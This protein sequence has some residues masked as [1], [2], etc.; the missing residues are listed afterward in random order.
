MTSVNATQSGARSQDRSVATFGPKNTLTEVKNAR[1]TRVE[2]SHTSQRRE[3]D[4][5]PSEPFCERSKL[6]KQNR[7][8]TSEYMR[9]SALANVLCI[10]CLSVL[11]R[12]PPKWPL[13]EDARKNHPKTAKER[14]ALSQLQ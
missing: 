5:K 1:L 13:A 8:E 4:W 10:F 2:A 7:F 14:R 12:S 9:S 6:L 11:H 3:H